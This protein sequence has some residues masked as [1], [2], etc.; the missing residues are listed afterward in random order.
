MLYCY[1]FDSIQ[2]LMSF[3]A[4]LDTIF[5]SKVKQLIKA[6]RKEETF[7]LLLSGMLGLQKTFLSIKKYFSNQKKKSVD[8]CSAR[9]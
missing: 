6:R 1:Q 3:K 5:Y 9:L 4:S 2:S 7:E 8:F